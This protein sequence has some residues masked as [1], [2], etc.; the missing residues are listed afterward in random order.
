[1]SDFNF[2]VKNGREE[3]TDARLFFDNEE[4]IP[5]STNKNMYDILVMTNIFSSKSQARKNWAKTGANIPEGFSDFIV[6]KLKH[7]ICI[8]NPI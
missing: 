6:G 4:V 3:E 8:L 5:I 2:L 7:R 1:M